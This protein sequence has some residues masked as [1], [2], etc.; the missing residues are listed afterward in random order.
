MKIIEEIVPA[1]LLR[2]HAED[3]L[4]AGRHDFLEMQIAALEFRRNGIQ[5]GN[6][7]LDRASGRRMQFGGF[8]FTILD[9]Q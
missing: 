6:V 3:G 4:L 2:T 9:G 7:N 8:E 1:G 5:I